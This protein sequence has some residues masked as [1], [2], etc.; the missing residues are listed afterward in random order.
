MRVILSRRFITVNLKRACI[1]LLLIL[2]LLTPRLL[3][4][5]STSVDINGSAEYM[6]VSPPLIFNWY[7]ASCQAVSSCSDTESVTDGAYTTTTR[8]SGSAS[9]QY[10]DLSVGVQ[11]DS[12]GGPAS[13]V[14]DNL[15][16]DV[17]ISAA[18]SQTYV[19]EAPG[20]TSGFLQFTAFSYG[21]CFGP[22][23]VCPSFPGFLSVQSSTATTQI[24]IPNG[25]GP[26][27][28]DLPVDFNVPFV[29]T[30]SL[31]MTCVQ[32]NN[33][34]NGYVAEEDLS[35]VQPVVLDNS[36]NPI[37]EATLTAVPEISSCWLLLPVVLPV[38]PAVRR[39]LKARC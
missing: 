16:L 23:D 2:C 17:Q 14:I 11:L 29:F 13:S 39:R 21:G 34:D 28:V 26:S 27:V 10:G 3:A 20:Y 33:E 31:Q 24:D 15:W 30:A 12:E 25:Y 37:A 32:C 1:L 35:F 22:Y 18:F 9:A 7:Y 38:V 5:T 4:D 8:V 6:T 19:I 36:Q